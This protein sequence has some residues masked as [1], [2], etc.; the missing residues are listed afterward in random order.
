MNRQRILLLL[1]LLLAIARQAAADEIVDI[2]DRFTGHWGPEERIIH[3][4][5]GSITFVGYTWGGL[6]YYVD[7]DWS[8][9]SRLVFEL[10]EAAPCAIQPIILYKNSDAEAN[11]TNAGVMEA[12]IDLNPDKS[13]AV[14]QAALQTSTT[15]TLQIRR[16]YLVKEGGNEDVDDTP[17][18]DEEQDAR[19]M[20]NELMQ[21]NIDCIMDDLNDFPDSWVELYNGGTTAARLNLYSIG[22]SPQ[23]DE[24]WPLPNRK[25]K[26]G[27]HIIVYCDKVADSLHTQFRLESAKGGEVYLF[28]NG[29]LIDQVTGLKKQPAPNIAYGRKTDGSDEWGYQLTATPKEPNCGDI[30]D[31]DHILGEPVF[32]EEGRVQTSAGSI[33]LKLS[34][35]DDSPEGTEIR[36]TTDGTEPTP[37]STRYTTPLTVTTTTV[38]RAKLFCNGWLSPRSVTQ[39]YIFFPRQLTLPVISIATSDKYLNDSRLGIF[40]NNTGE[41]RRNW[42]RPINIEFFFGEGKQSAINQLCETRIAG[43]ASRGAQKKS[44]AIYAH[45]RFGEKR[46]DYEFFPDQCPGLTDFKSLVLRNAGNDFDYL[47]MRDAI[48]Q[49]TMASHADLDWQAWRPAIVYINGQYHGMLNIRERANEN[50]IYTHYDGLEDI[51]LIENWNDLKEGTW[52]AYNAFKAFYT[53]QGHTLTEF[54]QWMDCEEFTNLMIMNLYYN[55]FDFPGNNIIMWRPR[56]PLPT[57]GEANAPRWRWIAKDADFTM[58][59]YGQSADYNILE[60][61]YNPN[62]DGNHNWGANSSSATRLFRRLMDDAD[63]FRSFI[64][65]CAVYMGDFLNEQGTR[66]TWDPMYEQIKYEYPN[67]RRLINQWWPNYDNEVNA[68]RNWLKQR[69]SI[70][71]KQLASYYKLGTPVAMMVNWS[72]AEGDDQVDIVFN[73]IRLSEG[74]FDGQFFA[75]RDFTLE[76]KAGGGRQVTGWKV[77]QISAGSTSTKEVEG[78]LLS[79]QMPQCVRLIVNP[80]LGDASG[81]NTIAATTQ[82]SNEVYSLSG[83]RLSQP[84]KGVNIIGGKKV[85]VK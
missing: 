27:G 51:D 9:Y 11:Y 14:S 30:C 71:Y 29:Q 2:T 62:Y 61:L 44:M 54:E 78:P 73:G 16:I 15:G 39:S 35:P 69:T 21:S 67:H 59:L 77:Q 43:A 5:D 82:D 24:A 25:V 7:G 46:F 56:G 13:H 37:E 81:I 12:Y 26:A 34:I 64:D 66:A 65:H 41:K 31:H 68:A 3:N 79:M 18:P 83:Q 58:G 60:W 22:T 8:E 63:Y 49:R 6:S 76:G 19:L 23:P 20:I 4:T 17:E 84:R 75:H 40:T 80:I 33:S 28:R 48:V 10:K 32:S 57:E 50:N 42:R 72:K 38:L 70:F 52:D 55:N 85:L 36:Y 1:T 53:E 45:K 74:T 47:Y